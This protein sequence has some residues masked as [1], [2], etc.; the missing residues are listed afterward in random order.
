[1]QA[2]S[3]LSKLQVPLGTIQREHQLPSTVAAGDSSVL[4]SVQNGSV[5]DCHSAGVKFLRI[6]LEL[7]FADLTIATATNPAPNNILR[8][9][10]YIQLPQSSRDLTNKRNQDYKLTLWLGP[11]NLRTMSPTNIQWDILDITHQDGPFDLLAP[12]FNLLSCRT[13]NIA[14]YGKLKLLVV[15][16]ASDT[17]HETMFIVLIPGYSTEPHTVP[18]HI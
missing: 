12:S 9:E 6:Q 16:L 10:Y 14:V 7:D 11:A 5:R 8:G 18:N 2:L 3:H 13:N 1:M 15:H 4:L 17:I